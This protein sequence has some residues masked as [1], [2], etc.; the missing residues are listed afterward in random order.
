MDLVEGR[1]AYLSNYPGFSGAPLIWGHDHD[2]EIPVRGR[3]AW[4]TVHA[5]G[6][7]RVFLGYRYHS[8]DAFTRIP[9]ADEGNQHD[10]AAGDGIYGVSILPSGP[11]IQY[12]FYAENDSAGFF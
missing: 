10:S 11:V 9:M 4:V 7:N 8:C 1:V 6:A 2:P 3:E 12:Y 5:T